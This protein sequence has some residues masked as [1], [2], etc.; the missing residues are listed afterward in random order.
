MLPWFLL[1]I[2]LVVGTK[3]GVVITKMCLASSN[4]NN[5][6]QGTFL[7]KPHDDLFWFGKPKWL[8]HLL[9]FVLFQVKNLTFIATESIPFPDLDMG[10]CLVL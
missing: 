9:Q 5:V 10:V 4:E 8:L 3:L 2:I 1:K 7:V 6:I